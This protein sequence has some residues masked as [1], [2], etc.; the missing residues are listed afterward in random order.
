ML[1][2][3]RVRGGEAQRH[4]NACFTSA[5]R[6]ALPGAR[7][8]DPGSANR[9]RDADPQRDTHTATDTA[10]FAYAVTHAIGLADQAGAA[11]VLVVDRR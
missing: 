9:H 10:A 4:T 8:S 5:Y 7:C 3:S 11:S 6:H 1:G 2:I